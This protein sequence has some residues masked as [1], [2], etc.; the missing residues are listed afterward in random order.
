MK[1]IPKSLL[2]LGQNIVY[3]AFVTIYKATHGLGWEGFDSTW[4]TLSTSQLGRDI[5]VKVY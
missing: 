5:S 4:P 2:E 3:M 1:K